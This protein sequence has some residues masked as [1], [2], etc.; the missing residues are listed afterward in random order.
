MRHCWEFAPKSRP[1]F[2]ALSAQLGNLLEH[3][4]RQKL[5]DL[6]APYA[7]YNEEHASGYLNDPLLKRSS[8]IDGGSNQH[9][10]SYR[11][12]PAAPP[13]RPVTPVKPK[14]TVRP[15]AGTGATRNTDANVLDSV[16]L[17]PFLN[18]ADPS[19]PGNFIATEDYLNDN[20]INP[21]ANLSLQRNGLRMASPD[22]GS[23]HT[24]R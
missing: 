20:F 12:T 10:N 4:T 18:R 3:S 22:S 21:P 6:N 15:S 23:F 17:Q 13:P 14:R 8:Q 16:E 5:N 24:D 2:A 1:D 11:L 19:R 7:V 9:L